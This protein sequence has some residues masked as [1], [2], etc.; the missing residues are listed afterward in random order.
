MKAISITV[1]LTFLVYDIAWATNFSPIANTPNA[2]MTAPE[3]I[4][5]LAETTSRSLL[6][7]TDDIKKTEDAEV[8]FRSQLIPQKERYNRDAFQSKEEMR[9]R[10]EEQRRQMG[11]R[12]RIQ[13]D[14]MRQNFKDQTFNRQLQLNN[15]DILNEAQRINQQAERAKQKTKQGSGAAGPL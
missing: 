3:T 4:P 9:R 10:Q 13:E 1:V 6:N 11:Q 5:R 7:K 12:Q 2:S 8:S 15:Q 14:I